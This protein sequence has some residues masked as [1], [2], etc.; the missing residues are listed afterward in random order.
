MASSER[1]SPPSTTVRWTV[2]GCLAL[3][4]AVTLWLVGN[5]GWGVSWKDTRLPDIA[6]GQTWSV[7]GVSLTAQ[8]SVHGATLSIPGEDAAHATDGAYLVAVTVD[9]TLA[10]EDVNQD[11]SLILVGDGR[12]WQSTDVTASVTITDVVP[13]VTTGCSNTDTNGDPTTN[14]TM[15]A[16]FEVPEAA[17]SEIHA[18]KAT[19]QQSF[20][21]TQADTMQQIFA[22]PTESALLQITI[23]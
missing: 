12:T 10:S 6:E 9:Y 11:C 13:G 20:D 16:L 4:A 3:V 19:V 8:D 22:S 2:I 17:L 23:R 14:G 1:T 18:V 7:N 15:G 21:W 5:F